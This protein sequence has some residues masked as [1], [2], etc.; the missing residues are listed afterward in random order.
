VAPVDLCP[1]SR[2]ERRKRGPTASPGAPDRGR[3]RQR[4]F[5]DAMTYQVEM[6]DQETFETGV[7]NLR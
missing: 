7:V 5:E 1:T 3:A 4:L 6:L 2:S